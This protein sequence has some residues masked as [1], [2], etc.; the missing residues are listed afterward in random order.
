MYKIFF[1]RGI[2]IFFSVLMIIV[3]FPFL[4]IIAILI[5]I[6]MGSPV[7]FTQERVGK[8]LTLFKIFKFRSMKDKGNG[9][10]SDA[11]RV[12]KLG[13][14]LRKFSLDEFPQLINILK[15]E[16]SFIGP[17]PL[18][19][20]YIPYYNERE[21]KRQEVLPGM[22]SLADIKGRSH[23]T[24]EE[25]FEYDVEYVDNL[26]FRLDTYIFLQTV[27]IVLGAKD[28]IA[29]GRFNTDS[30]DIH[31]KKQNSIKNNIKKNEE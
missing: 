28:N 12:T 4:L 8:D 18:L 22:T 26:S 16:M 24:W 29:V 5:M 2:D 17:R 10:N 9:D 14:I 1:K 30:F 27:Y 13:R 31:R 19:K 15:G 23:L 21:I 11:A 7:F 20:R 6:D 25:Q 3:L